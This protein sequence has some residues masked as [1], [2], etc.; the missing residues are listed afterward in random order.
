MITLGALTGGIELGLIYSILALGVFLSFRTLN[1]PD[2]TVD[3][4][5]VTGGAISA[6]FCTFGFPFAPVLGLIVAFIGG[7]A[8]GAVT[9]LLNTKLRIQ[10][11]L[12]GILVMLGSYSI[13][14]RLMGDRANLPLMSG[15][16][17]YTSAKAFFSEEWGSMVFGALILA[18]L[19][20]LLYFFLKT[21]LGLAL[22]ATGDNE[23]MVRASGVGSGN[24]KLLG[25]SLSNGFVG[26]AGG[27][28]VQYQ[29]YADIGMGVGMVVIGL[30]SVI[31]GEVIFGTSRL[32]RR[33]IAVALGA[34]VY[35]LVLAVALSLGMKATDMKLISAVIVV[36][37]LSLGAFGESFS[38]R[39][40][41]KVM[42]D[43]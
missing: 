29:G 39:N 15:D 8:A 22:R 9:A 37:A 43:A 42:R 23:E 32:I 12:A 4:S 25:L 3:G 11:L 28:L 19:I 34:V 13:N 17:V 31:I 1:T 2:L 21:R 24:M 5:I 16:T 6:S 33:L 38:L 36:I 18:A 20:A 10:P 26:L 14:L 41:K 27:L 40:K 30:A 7:A 35:R